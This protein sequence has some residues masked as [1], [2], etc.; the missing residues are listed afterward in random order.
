MHDSGEAAP[1]RPA[2]SA[3][4]V[5]D[6]KTYPAKFIRGLA[7]LLATGVELD[8]TSDYSGGQETISFFKSLGLATQ[9]GAAESQTVTAPPSQ[10]QSPAAEPALA[11]TP[12]QLEP[13]E[14]TLA[15]LQCLGKIALISHDYNMPDSRGLYD[16]SEHFARINELCDDQRCDTILYA[17]Y[18]W[19]QDAPEA[20][21]YEA[22]F[23][24]L[25][26]VQRIILE[27]WEKP[28][29]PVHL[30]VWQRGQ[31]APVRARQRFATSKEAVSKKQEFI[32]DLPN[33]RVS[34]GLLVI[35]G[36][37]NIA[38]TVRGSD[39][40]PDPFGFTDSLRDTNV[41]CI[42]NPIHDYM[43]R[44]EM[45]KKRQHYSLGGRTVISVWNQGR[46]SEAELPWTLFHNGQERTD[47]IVEAPSSPFSERPDIRIGIV[48]LSSL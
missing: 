13:Q 34:D 12:R 40:V 27:V 17:L 38:S 14:Q 28:E 41:R 43:R 45:K 39:E 48:D 31:Q 15:D 36:E 30:E 10:P 23:G 11:V 44:P 37:T 2:R 24:G 25:V 7:Y 29:N 21:T 18:T 9:E 35:C 42:L 46:G 4:L 32:D 8:P 19:D 26:H 3:F 1:Q 5:L 6:G 22:V 47:A 16:Y 33:R 20:R